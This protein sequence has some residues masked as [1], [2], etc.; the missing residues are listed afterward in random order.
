MELKAIKDVSISA[1]D[2]QTGI[3]SM[4]LK[5]LPRSRLSG[6]VKAPRIHSM[7]LKVAVS[8]TATSNAKG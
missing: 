1:L 5:D 2:M 8:H 3:H 7:E 4:E 6:K